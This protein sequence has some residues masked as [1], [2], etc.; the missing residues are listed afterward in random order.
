MVDVAAETDIHL[1]DGGKGDDDHDH[2]EGDIFEDAKESN[3]R[4]F[5]Y[6][7]LSYRRT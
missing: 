4:T 6:I 5:G 7:V 3:E 2:D 1:A